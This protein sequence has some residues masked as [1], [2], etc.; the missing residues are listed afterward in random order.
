MVTEQGSLAR[1]VRQVFQQYVL[2]FVPASLFERTIAKIV[3]KE[4]SGNPIELDCV[5]I[6]VKVQ[7]TAADPEDTYP[8]LSVYRV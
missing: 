4:W 8:L 1:H 3:I 5:L 2:R 7:P 6:T